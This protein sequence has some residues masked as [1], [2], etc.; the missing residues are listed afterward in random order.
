MAWGR[1]KFKIVWKSLLAFIT[2]SYVLIKTKINA[3]INE[4]VSNLPQL[5]EIIPK[6]KLMFRDNSQ[7]IQA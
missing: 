7:I 4:R 1:V 2:P 6:E 5:E 3:C